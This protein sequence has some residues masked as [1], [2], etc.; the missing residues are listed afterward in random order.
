MKLLKQSLFKYGLLLSLI[1]SQGYVYGQ[2]NCI[3]SDVRV[4][5]APFTAHITYCAPL[6]ENGSPFP[7]LYQY[8]NGASTISTSFTYT[9]PGVYSVKQRIAIE[10]GKPYADSVFLDFFRVVTSP[11]LLVTITN[12]K[13]KETSIRIDSSSYDFYIVTNNI[14]SDTDTIIKKGTLVKSFASNPALEVTFHIQGKY[15]TVDCGTETD[16]TIE[17]I[18]EIIPSVIHQVKELQSIEI[19]QQSIANIQYRIK[20]LESGNLIDTKTFTNTD[21]TTLPSI[22]AY[23]QIILEATDLCNNTEEYLALASFKSQ[24]SFS[25]NQNTINHISGG[26]IDGNEEYIKY[27]KD[28]TTLSSST[29][30]FITCGSLDCY[31]ISNQ[32]TYNG[33]TF[34]HLSSGDCGTS[35]SID[36]PD[37]PIITIN[38]SSNNLTELSFPETTDI[39]SITIDDSL[40][41]LN[42][43]TID[44]PLT[45][46]CFDIYVTNTCNQSSTIKEFCPLTLEQ[47][48]DLLFWN[49][50]ESLGYSLAWISIENDTTIFETGLTSTWEFKSYQYFAQKFC[51]IVIEDETNSISNKICF[52]DQS[53]IFIP[54]L[55]YKSDLTLKLKEKYLST[56]SLSFFDLNGN[57]SIEWNEKSS[58][59]IENLDTGTYFYTFEGQSENGLKIIRKG[60]I[61]I[62]E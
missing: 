1:L 60:S 44:R 51:I 46:T 14:N 41:I 26:V 25:N 33:Y 24:T 7:T 31:A 39:I 42:K 35:Y 52:E 29:D 8:E 13:N 58:L 53:L 34:K 2:I 5:C 48:G 43:S 56:F 19:N 20:T 17:L 22:H 45:N 21:T 11:D 32:N 3:D 59:N 36:K 16:Y 47:D 9:E 6:Q 18:D 54:E 4:G 27:N 61:L 15:L 23:D 30:N 57:L 62:K 28:T 50:Q 37:L 55:A 49:N 38:N 12:C 40:F 10:E